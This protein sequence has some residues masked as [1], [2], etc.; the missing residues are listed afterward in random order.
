MK[1]YHGTTKKKLEILHPFATSS[2]AISKPVVCLTANPLIALFYVW[3]RPYKWVTW[4]EGESD[5]VIFTEHYENMLFDFYS[6]VSGSIYICD[7]NDPNITLANMKNVYVSESP[8]DVEREITVP[9]VYNEVLKQEMLGNVTVRRYSRL[10]LGEKEEISVS[11]IRAIHMQKLLFPSEQ[12]PKKE[13][14]EFV[15][16]HFP[17]EW[18]AAAEMSRQ[19]IARMIDAWRAA[20]K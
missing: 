5:H 3:D 15:Q 17:R 6:G 4:S 1:L 18:A 2:N 8:V 16:L 12:K 13:L 10:S 9:D 20:V 14:A 11:T 19:E 7:G